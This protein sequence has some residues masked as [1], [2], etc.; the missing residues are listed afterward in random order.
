MVHT[1]QVPPLII[2]SN[3]SASGIPYGQDELELTDS[4]ESPLF[5]VL[6]EPF[7]TCAGRR[8]LRDRTMLSVIVD[9]LTANG[10]IA[11][12]ERLQD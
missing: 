12:V 8:Y 11:D 10:K 9:D 3:E 6:I 7:D 4:C 5:S 2:L 1:G